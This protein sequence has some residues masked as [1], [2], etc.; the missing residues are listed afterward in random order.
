MY[1]LF[2]YNEIDFIL[3]LLI[4][5]W[6]FFG[7]MVVDFVYG[8]ILCLVLGIVLMVGNFNEIIRKFLKFFFV[9]SFLIMIWGLFY[10]SVFGDLIK[11]LI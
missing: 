10:G 7:M 4:F 2:K 1:V 8:L 11:L 9:L 3:I 5:Y 6:V